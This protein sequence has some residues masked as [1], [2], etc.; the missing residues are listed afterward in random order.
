MLAHHPASRLGL[1]SSDSPSNIRS[2]NVGSSLHGSLLNVESSPSGSLSN[3]RS[4]LSSSLSNVG[5]SSSSSLKQNCENRIEY[6][7]GKKNKK[8]TKSTGTTIRETIIIPD[9]TKTLDKNNGDITQTVSVFN[10]DSDNDSVSEHTVTTPP[11]SPISTHS[12][13]QS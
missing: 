11:L 12:T 3:V 13:S 9:I 8:K 1:S 5:S 6:L 4:S 2:F 10:C 7:R